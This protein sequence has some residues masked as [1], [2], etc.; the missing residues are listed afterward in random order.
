MVGLAIVEQLKP[1]YQ[2][3]HIMAGCAGFV[4]IGNVYSLPWTQRPSV[5]E[6][7]DFDVCPPKV[8]E[9]GVSSVYIWLLDISCWILPVE[10]IGIPGWKLVY[11]PKNIRSDAAQVFSMGIVKVYS[12]QGE[13]VWLQVSF[14]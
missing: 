4:V 7:S 5:F 12:D 1:L 2:L 9:F 11:L 6:V 8:S 13:M 3:R 14:G 10:R